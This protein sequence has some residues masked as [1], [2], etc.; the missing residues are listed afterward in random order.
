M[1]ADDG[2]SHARMDDGNSKNPSNPKVGRAASFRS[3]T[4]E[5]ITKMFSGKD[6][7]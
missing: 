2:C 1:T 3:K 7:L 5:T 4:M 6:N